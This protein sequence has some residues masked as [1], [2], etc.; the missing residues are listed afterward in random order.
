MS[1]IQIRGF[2]TVALLMTIIGLA[3]AI[4][5]VCT[6]LTTRNRWLLALLGLLWAALWSGPFFFHAVQW[7]WS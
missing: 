7:I 1:D 3:F 6:A 5:G 2:I 4:A